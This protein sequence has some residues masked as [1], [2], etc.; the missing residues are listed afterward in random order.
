MF[1]RVSNGGSVD[2]ITF[3]A[4]NFASNANTSGGTSI[5]YTATED[6]YVFGVATAYIAN[7]NPGVGSITTSGGTILLSNSHVGAYYLCVNYAL[8]KLPKGASVTV[9]NTGGG[10]SNYSG[11]LTAYYAFKI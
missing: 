4:S 6:C 2:G 8:I 3:I 9:T 10:G 7:S 11:R 1:Y 5:S